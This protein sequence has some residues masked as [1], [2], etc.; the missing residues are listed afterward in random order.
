LGRH[1][2]VAA[3][4]GSKAAISSPHSKR[5]LECGNS[6]PL[7]CVAGGD[8]GRPAWEIARRLRRGTGRKRR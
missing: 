5:V 8:R 1:V 3:G 2:A 7:F 4:D 6:L